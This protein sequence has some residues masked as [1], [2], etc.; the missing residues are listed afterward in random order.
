MKASSEGSKPENA[1]EKKFVNQR[2][3]FVKR[4]WWNLPS[5]LPISVSK[6]ATPA[7]TVA[8]SRQRGALGSQIG[9]E[10]GQRLGWPVYDRE[11]LDMIAERAVLRTELLESIDEHDRPWLM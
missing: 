7:I 5:E 2:L 8:I 6:K 11:L 10:A 1:D 3:E 9:A 4:H